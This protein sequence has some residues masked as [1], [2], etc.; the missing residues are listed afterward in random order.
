MYPSY[1]LLL[2]ARQ[3][4]VQ[5]LLREAAQSRLAKNARPKRHH[6]TPLHKLLSW[7]DALSLR[8]KGG[9]ASRTLPTTPLNPREGCCA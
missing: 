2:L 9:H 5:D 1:H 6:D 4:H 8:R 3:E 7:L